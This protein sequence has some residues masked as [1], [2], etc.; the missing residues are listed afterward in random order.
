MKTHSAALAAAAALTLM[1]GACSGGGG[2]GDADGSADSTMVIW[3]DPERTKALQPFAEDFGAENGVTV[4]V[5]EIPRDDLQGDFVTAHEAGNGPDIVV[6]AH[7]WTGNLVQNGAIDPVELPEDKAA[8]FEEVA[9]EAVTFDGKLYGVPYAM[10]NLMLI[11]NTELA[12]DAPEDFDELVADGTD[13]KDAGKVKE[14]LGLQVSQ[15]GDPFHLH[16]FYVSAGGYLFGDDGEGGFDPQDLGVGTPESVQ[17]FEK[18]AEYGEKGKGAFKRSIDGDNVASLFTG[19]DTAYFVTGPW[20]LGAIK[21]AG[22]D[23]DISPVPGFADGEAARPFL[24]VQTFFV[25]SGGKNKVLGQE[26]VTNYVTGTDLAVALYEADPRPPALTAA[27]EQV[28][29]KD[30]DIAKMAEAGKDAEPMPS[31]PA[32]GEVWDPLGKAE[33]AVIGGADPEDA[34]KNAGAAIAEKIG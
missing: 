25:A 11:R 22:I 29:K 21:D 3:A 19:G 15:V 4:E 26:F 7:D 14:I 18:I 12:P 24:G 2:E 20:N 16:P 5:Q 8:G 31:I 9:L 27:L 17:A 28:G 23:Y 33:A 13:L 6:G 30:K 1:V 34:A 10:E 32:M